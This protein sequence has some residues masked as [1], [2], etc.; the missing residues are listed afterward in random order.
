M[1]QRTHRLSALLVFCL[2][3]GLPPLL[4]AQETPKPPAVK[5]PVVKLT[6]EQIARRSPAYMRTQMPLPARALAYGKRQITRMLADRPSMRYYVTAGDPLYTY[7]L[8]MFAGAAAGTP[9]AWHNEPPENADGDHQYPNPDFPGFIRVNRIYR[10]GEHKGQERM[11]PELWENALFELNNIRNARA[12][13]RLTNRVYDGKINKPKYIEGMTRL[14]FKALQENEE[15]YTTLWKPIMQSR[16]IA[17]DTP[18]WWDQVPSTYEAWI[19]GY[20]DLND[21]PW[22]CYGKYYDDLTAYAHTLDKPDQASKSANH[23]DQPFSHCI[24]IEYSLTV[25][26]FSPPHYEGGGWG[27]VRCAYNP[28]VC[29]PSTRIVCPVIKDAASEARKTTMFASSAGRP[30][31]PSGI[32]CSISFFAASIVM[33]ACCAFRS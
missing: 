19:A 33:P 5:A 20:T 8:R 3:F 24:A 4:L 6:E 12:F 29:P 16:G 28:N 18:G 30:S 23:F 25:C 10:K 15:V 32:F 31:L 17:V 21:Y 2:L 26:V 13:D 27:V 1:K 7:T 22:D 9:I 14:E 11:G